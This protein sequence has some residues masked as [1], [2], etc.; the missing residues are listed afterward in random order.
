MLSVKGEMV[1][2]SPRKAS[3]RNNRAF[4]EDAV[5]PEVLHTYTNDLSQCKNVN[6]NSDIENNKRKRRESNEASGS[7]KDES[8]RRLIVPKLI[9]SPTV[10]LS[11]M[12]LK[13]CKFETDR[14]RMFRVSGFISKMFNISLA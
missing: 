4:A 9:L 11:E 14:E 6:L 13:K 8:R 7:D 12:E 3:L 5:E 1:G 10:N 2:L